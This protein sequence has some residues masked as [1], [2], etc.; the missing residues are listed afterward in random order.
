MVK[1]MTVKIILLRAQPGLT[2]LTV[3]LLAGSCFAAPAVKLSVKTGPPTIN[4]QISGS[5]FPA[6]AAIDIYFDT[7][8]LALAAASSTGS[9]SGIEIQVPASAL[10]GTNWVTGVARV[11]GEAAQATF[12]VQTNWPQFHIGPAHS[13]HNVY[14]NVLSTTTVGSLDLLWSYTTGSAVI[15]SPAVV[16]GVVY[17][18]SYDHSVYALNA[19]TGAKLWRFTTGGVVT[20]SPAVVDGVVYVGSNDHNVYALNATTG[21]KLWE[22][23]TGLYVSDGPTVANGV[24]YVGSSDANVYALNA[25]TGAK[26][27]QFTTGDE[28]DVSPASTARFMP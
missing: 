14:E 20:S 5:G 3:L 15:S 1:T 6:F 22:F 4:L 2:L 28:V 9:F 27:W 25:T 11:S 24:V 10:P 23:A 16:N 17:V 26:L 7:T 18:G 13:G 21:A 12:D 8:D 19:T